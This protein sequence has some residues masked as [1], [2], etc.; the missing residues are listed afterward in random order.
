[1][2]LPAERE[3]PLGGQN[4]GGAVVDKLGCQICAAFDEICHPLRMK[5]D[6][7]RG[8]LGKTPKVGIR[9]LTE[10]IRTT[11]LNLANIIMSP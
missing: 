4:L 10:L 11:R 5:H 6:P 7:E 9:N 2:E 3:A 8:E 1:M